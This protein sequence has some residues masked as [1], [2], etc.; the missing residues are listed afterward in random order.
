MVCDIYVE[1]FSKSKIYQFG[2]KEYIMFK[3]DINLVISWICIQNDVRMHILYIN[4]YIS[5]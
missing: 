3:R 4:M 5:H 1:L 2:K